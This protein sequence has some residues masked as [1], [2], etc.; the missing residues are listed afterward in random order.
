MVSLDFDRSLTDTII[1]EF[2]KV[3]ESLVDLENTEMPELLHTVTGV[4]ISASLLDK[5][6]SLGR[7]LSTALDEVD[8]N[9]ISPSSIQNV[10]E[11]LIDVI[12]ELSRTASASVPPEELGSRIIGLFVG[13]YLWAQRPGFASLLALLGVLEGP[14]PLP[15][16]VRDQSELD[17]NTDSE[18]TATELDQEPTLQLFQNRLRLDRFLKL[19]REPEIWAAEVYGWGG[20]FDFA[21]LSERIYSLM[22]TVGLD[23]GKYARPSWVMLDDDSELRVSLFRCGEVTSSFGEVALIFGKASF[24]RA[25]YDGIVL[26]LVLVG[27]VAETLIS[28]P[29]LIVTF[30]TE[31]DL[32]DGVSILFK[33]NNAPTF[34]IGGGYESAGPGI[35]RLEITFEAGDDKVHQWYRRGAMSLSSQGE[36]LLLGLRG[37]LLNPE[38]VAELGIRRMEFGFDTSDADSFLSSI[39]GAEIIF[40]LDLAIGCSSQRGFYLAGG[41]GLA[42]VIPTHVEIGPIIVER[43]SVGLGVGRDT[44]ISF[45]TQT[46][47]SFELGPVSGTVSGLGVQATILFDMGR[48][49]SFQGLSFL[50]PTGVG[51]VFNSGSIAGGGFLD[52]DQTNKCYAGIVQLNA[53]GQ[54][55]VGIGL[56]ATQMPDGSDG[57]SLLI[58]IGV[59]FTP[60]I[61]LPCGFSLSGV[62]GLIALN[63]SMDTEFLRAGLRENA[64]D[65]ILF[66][67]NPIN[68]A[69]TIISNLRS[70]FPPVNGRVI[71]GPMVKLNWGTPRIIQADIGIFIELPEPLRPVLLGQISA[72]L[73]QEHNK[74]IEINI[75]VLGVIDFEK[76]TLAIDATLFKSRIYEYPL[77]GDAAVR[78]SWGNSPYLVLSL[79]G[80]HPRFSP[81]AGFPTLRRLTLNLS[82]GRDLQLVCTA[83]HAIT[84]NTI[85]FGAAIALLVRKS[86]ATLEGQLSFDTL[87]CLSPFGFDVDIKANIVARYKGHRLASVRLHMQLSGPSPWHAR[88]RATFGILCWDVTVR[89]NETWG[90]TTPLAIPPED[91]WPKLKAALEQDDSWGAR[92]PSGIR[93]VEILSLQKG[94]EGVVLVHPG[95]SLEVRQNVLPLEIE[96]QKFGG[97]PLTGKTYFSIDEVTL[98]LVSNDGA[99]NETVLEAVDVEDDFAPAQFLA[100][101]D[102]ER[103]S[104]PAF[105]KMKAG[106]SIAANGIDFGSRTA[107][108]PR[109]Y[110]SILV[111]DDGTSGPVH[112]TKMPHIDTE[113]LKVQLQA[114]AAG[115]YAL[116]ATGRNKYG[117]SEKPQLVKLAPEHY[118]V[119][120]TGTMAPPSDL[121]NRK[122]N[123]GRIQAE[124]AALAYC[125][126]N[127]SSA[128]HIKVVRATEVTR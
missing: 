13:R 81:P 26:T 49:D 22:L 50:P 28:R 23:A 60:P 85:Q 119:I 106:V 105:E 114:S 46:S 68:N 35:G 21:N 98:T 2:S 75:D 40:G 72:T 41:G 122:V 24:G 104:K 123:M 25:D 47:I 113:A 33:P 67:E 48:E 11:C 88:G 56:I 65:S 116:N 54:D 32:S 9:G 128:A 82:Q 100:L 76:E 70:A 38:L 63:R 74:I 66:P 120:N 34:F 7:K 20:N 17:N 30:K 31:F 107:T 84:S 80:F 78:F 79:G 121:P 5:L 12:G 1:L 57:F 92:L 18:E 55:L 102:S 103:L 118:E 61:Q 37:D 93:A 97:A 15:G 112:L 27:R 77:S 16:E 3:F 71:I 69:A 126:I 124:Q 58:N 90:P 87:I 62:G 111:K 91:A 44:G 42:A 8:I 96:L 53:G 19:L 6:T 29:D 43:V 45:Y 51:L 83:Y 117:V 109:N 108:Q 4:N 101:S 86:G 94:E 59:E 64:L 99:T 52:F 14:I 89:F 127:P 36:K 125:K 73:P 115:R 10:A 110:E 39:L 95:G